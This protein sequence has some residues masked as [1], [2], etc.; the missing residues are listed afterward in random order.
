AATQEQIVSS[1]AQC[2]QIARCRVGGYFVEMQNHARKSLGKP[3][4]DMRHDR[5][6]DTQRTRE[7]DFARRWVGQQFDILNGVAQFVEDHMNSFEQGTA[8]TGRLDAPWLAI[9]KA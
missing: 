6:G 5:E 9:K 2:S 3:L 8:G 7:A 1:I 4:E